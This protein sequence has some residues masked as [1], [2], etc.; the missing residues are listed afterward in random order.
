MQITNDNIPLDVDGS[1]KHEPTN[2]LMRFPGLSTSSIR[3]HDYDKIEDWDYF[4]GR[5]FSAIGSWSLLLVQI[6]WSYH[7]LLSGIDFGG[8]IL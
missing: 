2:V 4:E 5:L 1:Q 8:I 7:R 3:D 6:A